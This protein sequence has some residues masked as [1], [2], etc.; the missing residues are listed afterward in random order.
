MILFITMSD[1]L[2]LAWLPIVSNILAQLNLPQYS[3][4]SV[5]KTGHCTS[6]L[7]YELSNRIEDL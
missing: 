4:P 2:D 1:I 6:R 3:R 7:R 5:A